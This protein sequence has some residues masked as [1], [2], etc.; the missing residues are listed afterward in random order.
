M[1][2][3]CYTVT[4]LSR[5]AENVHILIVDDNNLLAKLMGEAMKRAGY[6][7]I[8]ANSGKEF[9][10]LLAD[11][12]T[13]PFDLALLDLMMPDT[14]G[15]IICQ[16]LRQDPRTA[17]IPIIIVSAIEK[18]EKRIELLKLGANDYITKPFSVDELKARATIQIEL[19]HLR[20]AKQAAESQLEAHNQ[21]LRAAIEIGQEASRTLDLEQM[22]ANV[23]R[24]LQTWLPC[25]MCAI[26]LFDWETE[27]LSLRTQVP[28]TA[29]PPAYE[30][31][32]TVV[33]TYKPYVS[34]PEVIVPLVRDDDVILGALMV[35]IAA[36]MDDLAFMSILQVLANQITSAVTNSYLVRD[37][38]KSNVE[39]KQI[40][41]ENK[42]LLNLEHKQRR[43]AEMLHQMAQVVSSSLNLD[44]VIHTA[45]NSL[46]QTLNV[47]DGSL[48][49]L[50]EES[51][52]LSFV[53]LVD[54]S[55]DYLREVRVDANDG[56][57]GR[58]LRERQTLCI[59]DAQNDPDFSP[60][61]DRI[62]GKT[63]QSVLCAP[64]ITNDKILGA[65]ELINHIDGPFTPDDVKFVSSAVNTI[66]VALDNARLH[67]ELS[68]LVTQLQDSQEKLI[69]SEK[70]AATGRLAASLAHEI[71]NPL[72]TIHSS[73]QLAVQFDLGPEKREEYLRMANDEIERLIDIVTRILQFARPSRTAFQETEINSVVRHVL[74][75]ADKHIRSGDCEIRC[76]L[77]TD[78][79]EVLV[80]PDQIAQVLLNLLLNAF[81]AIPDNGVITLSTK[82][83]GRFVEIR[84]VDSGVGIPAANMQQIFEPFYTT[85]SEGSGLGLAVSSSII[86]RHNGMIS[87]ESEVNRG[88]TF[89]IQLPIHETSVMAAPEELL[90]NEF[91]EAFEYEAS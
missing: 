56:I 47:D 11:P 6:R 68:D 46:R 41:Q 67:R 39:L 69:H 60:T 55:M 21:L 91:W 52:L 79:P 34:P 36:D 40:L 24:K 70:L 48:F 61:I 18:L 78:L 14:D 80:I 2:V 26:Y 20:Q 89:T 10:R 4:Q 43:Q 75:F 85:K 28:D 16:Q 49:V 63:T 90:D 9:K 62:T 73:I 30:L 38:Q 7:S 50:D 1:I 37:I 76:Q 54:D 25:E 71:N 31:V 84:V 64:L 77:A 29:V 65:V 51:G 59:N 12:D 13:P 3:E 81:D 8:I 66:A 82:R 53:G 87:V 15:R 17:N 19:S 33:T 5:S 23:S 32:E 44:S 88:T 42:R 74:K 58:C 22:L 83:A 27:Q 45:M 57:V 35:R 86:D 72:Q